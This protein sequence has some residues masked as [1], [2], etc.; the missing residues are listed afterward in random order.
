MALLNVE[1]ATKD[2]EEKLESGFFKSRYPEP[3]GYIDPD[4]EYD[5]DDIEGGYSK[6]KAQR[7]TDAVIA[8]AKSDAFKELLNAIT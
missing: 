4:N 6:Y 2:F 3:Q 5:P 1:E 7:D 8:F